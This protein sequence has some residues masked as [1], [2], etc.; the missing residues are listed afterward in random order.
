MT[1][2]KL[3]MGLAVFIAMFLLA[4]CSKSLPSDIVPK[5]ASSEMC[6]NLIREFDVNHDG[7]LAPDEV[8]RIKEVSL[9]TRDDDDFR[10]LEFLVNMEEVRGNCCKARYLDL[11]QNKKLKKVDLM[12]VK[13]LT[14]IKVPESLQILT[15]IRAKSFTKFKIGDMPFLQWLVVTESPV[16]ELNTG[17]CPS[18]TTLTLD[19]TYIK[20]VDLS[21]FPR[22]ERLYCSNTNINEID[23]SM[24]PN[25]RM[26]R[27]KGVKRITISKDQKIEGINADPD[28]K[29]A[30]DNDTQIIIK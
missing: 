5:I 9:Y 26:A 21:K 6:E 1:T 15:L 24:L 3:L 25:L 2:K 18:V 20:D 7:K 10:G 30:L 17:E 11:S 28:Y 4:G 29:Y 23:L 14:D 16:T 12:N 19:D 22:L 13:E 8:K 27:C